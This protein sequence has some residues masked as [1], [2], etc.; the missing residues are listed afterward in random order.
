T[1]KFKNVTLLNVKE[2]S[3]AVAMVKTGELDMAMVGSDAAASLKTAGFRIVTFENGTNYY[4]WPWYDLDHPETSALSDVRVRKALQLGINQK[5]IADK[6]LGGFGAPVAM[7]FVPPNAYF[8]DANQIKLDPFDP[9]GAKKLLADAGQASGF[10][11]KLW[12]VGGGAL[13]STINQAV[14]GYWRKIGVNVETVP[15]DFAAF[16]PKYNPKPT[17]E[18]WNTLW[19]Y[20][21]NPRHFEQMVHYHSTK[22]G[23]KN[24]RMP[25]LDALIDQVPATAD[26]V[27]RKQLALQAAVMGKNAYSMLAVVGAYPTVAISPK[28][29][30]IQRPVRSSINSLVLE[31]T[32]HSK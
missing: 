5:E 32:T 31:V 12:D 3:T 19:T 28:I 10:N 22:G 4:V 16:R 18:I 29:G 6:L 17:P 1:P 14:A 21:T 9:E 20:R 25:E 15:M 24:I 2:E 27:K 7:A 11:T 13:L 23:A 8:F 26:P 30:E